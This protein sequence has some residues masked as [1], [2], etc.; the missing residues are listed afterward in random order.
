M[1]VILLLAP[2]LFGTS[3]PNLPQS[4]VHT[5]TYQS[6]KEFDEPGQLDVGVWPYVRF[7]CGLHERDTSLREDLSRG[8][9]PST[10]HRLGLGVTHL[11]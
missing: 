4:Y 1:Y 9:G 6:L 11:G 5:Y 8:G 10:R 3:T 2:M 7:E